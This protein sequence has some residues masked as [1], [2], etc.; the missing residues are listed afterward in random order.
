MKVFL[1]LLGVLLMIAPSVSAEEKLSPSEI[2]ARARATVGTEENLEEL[3][4][5]KL[6][7][8]LESADSS[9]PEATLLILARKP[10]S[11]RL[12]IRVGDLVETTILNG[13]KGC[14]VRSNLSADSS[15]MRLLRGEELE[16]VRYT[17]QQFFN[18]YRP[19]FKNGEKVHHDGTL[20]HR[21]QRVHKLR[22]AYPDG[23]ETIR[24]FSTVED[25]LVAM[26][27]ENGVESINLGE[28]VV[29][30]IKYPERIEYYEDGRKLH[31]V[32]L[33]EIQVNKPLPGGVFKIPSGSEN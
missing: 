20:S 31:S 17:T 9:V 26:V 28:Q 15:Q 18:F 8:E 27:S 22:Y 2:I 21:G 5:L 3:V 29:G 32:V 11:Q 16:R 25:D 19:D 14:I 4:T 33:H 23:S 7:G 10:C 24:Y 6:V 1:S 13:K 12:E 30:G